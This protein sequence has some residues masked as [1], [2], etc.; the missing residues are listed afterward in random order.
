M[1]SKIIHN[2]RKNIIAGLFFLLPIAIT[3]LVLEFLFR[4]IDS[5]IQP[6]IEP[7]FNQIRPGLG[8]RIPPGVGIIIL[9][10]FIY[11][12]GL[13]GSNMLGKWIGRRVHS[14]FLKMP[15]VGLIY[16]TVK[17]LIGSFSGEGATGFKRVVMIEY[18]KENCWAIGFL[19]NIFNDE[20]NIPM[21]TI[22]LPTSPAPN[23]GW[24]LFVPIHDVYD[25]NLNIQEALR[26]VVSGGTVKPDMIKKQ[27][28]SESNINE[29]K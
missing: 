25:T 20:N 24:V 18:P 8:R 29:L 10:I 5:I 16:S 9:A 6:V 7:I 15:L 2:I 19:T 4:T 28:I 26:I 27:P 17:Q 14:I 11:F 12:A 22:Y 21:A 13:L 23:T 1:N 3:Y